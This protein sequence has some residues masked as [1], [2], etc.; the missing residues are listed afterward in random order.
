MEGMIADAPAGNGGFGFDPIL[1]IPELKKTAAELTDH[2]K[3][4]IS[5]RGK[6]LEAMKAELAAVLKE[7]R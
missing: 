3:N 2:Q 1:Y 5:H 4:K 6:A 7:E